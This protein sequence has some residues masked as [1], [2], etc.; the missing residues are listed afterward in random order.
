MRPSVYDLFTYHDHSIKP[1]WGHR[2]VFTLKC[3]VSKVSN[4]CLP[5]AFIAIID[6]RK[7]W[8]MSRLGI[9]FSVN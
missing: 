5:H 8:S 6:D 3:D 2:Y 7:A 1:P 4:M 9:T